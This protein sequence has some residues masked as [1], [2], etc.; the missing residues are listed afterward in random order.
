MCRTD[1]KGFPPARASE[2]GFGQ[3]GQEG[4]G[5][6]KGWPQVRSF[7]CSSLRFSLAGLIRD[8]LKGRRHPRAQ[9][10]RSR[11]DLSPPNL[12][13]SSSIASQEE[14]YCLWKLD[15]D[16]LLLRFRAETEFVECTA[17]EHR[18]FCDGRS[19][20]VCVTATLHT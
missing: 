20:V 10:G 9:P 19:M 15:Q 18:M 5:R 4:V 13:R 16:Y 14:H 8:S 7:F 6:E 1:S 17:G 2:R 11:W 3:P 12:E